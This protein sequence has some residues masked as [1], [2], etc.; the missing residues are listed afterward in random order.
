MFRM[1]SIVFFYFEVEVSW[2]EVFILFIWLCF[3]FG[4]KVKGDKNFFIFIKL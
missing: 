3:C 1:E 4:V 2:G